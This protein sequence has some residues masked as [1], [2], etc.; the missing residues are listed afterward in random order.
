VWLYW[1]GE[2]GKEDVDYDGGVGGSPPREYE[3]ELASCKP[4]RTSCRR[5]DSCVVCL[6]C[7]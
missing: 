4:E 5:C 1:F 6:L 2:K 7:N 3:D